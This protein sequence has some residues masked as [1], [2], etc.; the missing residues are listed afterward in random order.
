MSPST[1]PL[2]L[3]PN[4]AFPEQTFQLANG[5]HLTLL[6]DGVPEATC[7]GELFGFE[8]AAGLSTSPA[9]AIAEAALRFGQA[10]DIT[11]LTIVA[12]H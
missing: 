1:L 2:G 9:A 6:T 5:D 7:R 11:V 3:D 10:D 4:A 8:R 12:N